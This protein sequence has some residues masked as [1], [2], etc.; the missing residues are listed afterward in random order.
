MEIS[1]SGFTKPF[2]C[3][4]LTWNHP[5][6]LKLQV[7]DCCLPDAIDKVHLLKK[8]KLFFPSGHSCRL[9]VG[10]NLPHSFLWGAQAHII[11]GP[12]TTFFTFMYKELTFIFKSAKSHVLDE[13]PKFLP[14]LAFFFP[15]IFQ[16]K[17]WNKEPFRLIREKGEGSSSEATSSFFLYLE[18]SSCSSI[19]SISVSWDLLPVEY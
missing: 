3:F 11:L 16:T 4:Q 13:L 2:L 12:H 7:F 6:L 10:R 17:V 14:C 15:V 8:K 5:S 19:H 18:C 9:L 1:Q